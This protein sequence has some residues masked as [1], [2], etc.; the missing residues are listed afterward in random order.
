MREDW[1]YVTF[2]N[3]AKDMDEATERTVAVTLSLNRKIREL[4]RTVWALVMA[5]GGEIRVRDDYLFIHEV[6]EVRRA[7]SVNDM[8]V[9]FTAEH[10][11]EK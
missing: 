8:T 10:R 1:D 7:A 11:G 9:R 4:E 6:G 3:Y 5:A 2:E